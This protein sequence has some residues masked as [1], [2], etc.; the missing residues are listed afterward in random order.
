MLESLINQDFWVTLAGAAAVLLQFVLTASVILRVILTRHPPGSSF[1]WI[2]LVTILPYIGFI[3]YVWLGERPIGRWRALRLRHLLKH[4]E[5][6]TDEGYAISGT[7][8]TMPHGQ[9]HKGLTRLA[10]RLGD[11]PMSCGSRLELIS[12]SVEALSRIEYDVNNARKSVS[13]EFYIWGVGGW[14]DRV[15]QAIIHAAERGCECRILVDDIGARAWLRSS[16]PSK[17]LAAGVHVSR[18]LP[19]SLFP[20]TKGRADLRLHRKTVIIDDRLGYTGSLNLIDPNIFNANEGVGEWVDAMVR[21]EGTAVRDLNQVFLFD[22]ALQPDIEGELISLEKIAPVPA[23]GSACVTVVPSGPTTVDD[24]NQR[25][26]LEAI[27]CARE[28]IY[29]TTPY[30]I[31]GETLIL[32]LQNAAMRGVDVRLCIPSKPDSQFVRWA[33]RRYFSDLMN[34]GVKISFFTDGLLHTKAI[35][36]DDTFSLFGTV[37]LDKRSLHLNFEMMLLIFDPKF[38]AD[39]TAL[40]KHYE[41]RSTAIDPVRWHNRSI[42]QR[43]LEGVCYLISPL[44]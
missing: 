36:V 11:L 25:L 23:V 21:V 32:A 6:V 15:A 22:W 12:D 19:V 26:I 29:L 17:M 4:W 33:S 31:P 10:E 30:F 38:V 28:R 24:A 14:C 9:R 16:W 27:S 13:M 18:A 20:I 1:A 5:E 8:P 40:H 41:S 43:F 3:L 35:T 37:N 2:L 42:G 44:L 34:A 7:L 39:M